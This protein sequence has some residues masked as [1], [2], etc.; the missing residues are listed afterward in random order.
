VDIAAIVVNAVAIEGER[1]ISKEQYR[2]AY[3]ALPRQRLRRHGRR[4]RGGAGDRRVAI[5]EIVEFDER[6]RRLA[7]TMNLMS[8]FHEHERSA[9]AQLF[10]DVDDGGTAGDGV[11]DAKRV[12]EFELAAAPHP[13]RKRYR[14]KKATALG[15]TVGT[16][17][18]LAIDGQKI[19]PVPQRRQ[20]SASGGP[21]RGPVER[22]REGSTRCRGDDI[23]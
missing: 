18:R 3:L 8:H 15:V 12:R 22:R 16:D 7:V 21:R 11:T 14:R 2:Q 13:P 4:W 17:V 9:A 1:R 5:D 6:G 20:G 10:G 23:P 19:Q